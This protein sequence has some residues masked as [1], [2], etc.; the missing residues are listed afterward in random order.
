VVGESL[1]EDER[2]RL[3]FRAGVLGSR[4]DE[5]AGLCTTEQLQEIQPLSIYKDAFGLTSI[6]SVRSR[7]AD[8]WNSP[9]L[10]RGSDWALASR[11]RASSEENAREWAMAA[12]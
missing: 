12:W 2:R 3:W 7:R 1:S 11:D 4:N 5:L 10:P 6:S 8:E 9:K